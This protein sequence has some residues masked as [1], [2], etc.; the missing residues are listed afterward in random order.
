MGMEIDRKTLDR[1]LSLNDATLRAVIERAARENGIDLSDFNIS[2]GDVA[3]IRRALSEATDD[4]LR[5]VA[6]KVTAAREAALRK[7]HRSGRE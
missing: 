4:D 6:E 1:L 2:D 3:G 7:K 5:A